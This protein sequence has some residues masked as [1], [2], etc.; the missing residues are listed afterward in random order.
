RPMF[1]DTVRESWAARPPTTPNPNR[2]GV[3][4]LRVLPGARGR[5]SIPL[6][7]TDPLVL[8]FRVVGAI[9][10]IGCANLA[11]LLLARASARRQEVVMR[12]TLGASRFRIIRQFL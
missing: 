6:T 5:N 11:T 7:R 8:S 1:A 10:L 2:S 4:E 9:L 3:P 12:M